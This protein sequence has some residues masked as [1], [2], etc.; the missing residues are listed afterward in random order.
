MN[1]LTIEPK[2]QQQKQVI[3][4]EE[5]INPE[6]SPG[7]KENIHAVLSKHQECFAEGS[8]DL[9]HCKVLTHRIITED[10]K[11]IHQQPIPSAFKQWELLT[12]Q[13]NAGRWHN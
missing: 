3:N 11:P 4:I 6:L 1:A 13:R 10:E 5:R 2:H 9:G 12:C 8:K 7:Q